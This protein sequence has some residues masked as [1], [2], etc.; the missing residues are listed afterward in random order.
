MNFVDGGNAIT[1]QSRVDVK[2]FL[3]STFAFPRTLFLVAS[4]LYSSLSSVAKRITVFDLLGSLVQF[5]K[6]YNLVVHIVRVK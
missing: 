3:L 2:I 5:H 6:H 4:C 1:K